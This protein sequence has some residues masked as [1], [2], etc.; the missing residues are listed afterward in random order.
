MDFRDSIKQNF[1]QGIVAYVINIALFSLLILLLLFYTYASNSIAFYFFRIVAVIL[2][3][4]FCMMQMYVYQMISNLYLNLRQVYKN[5]FLL[6]FISL[7]QNLFAF[8]IGIVLLAILFYLFLYVPI[9]G[10]FVIMTL[11]YSIVIF[12]QIFITNNTVNKYLLQPETEHK[13]NDNNTENYSDATMTRFNQEELKNASSG[14]VREEYLNCEDVKLD[15]ETD[16]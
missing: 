15:Y 5:A 1:K 4:I 9:T 2:I 7:P 6:T 11:L 10:A 8:I 14:D 3:V 12:T 13:T 16:V